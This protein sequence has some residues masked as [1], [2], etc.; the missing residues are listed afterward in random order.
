MVASH[1][2]PIGRVRVPNPETKQYQDIIEETYIEVDLYTDT[3]NKHQT[4]PSLKPKI[5][6]DL[7]FYSI[8][9]LL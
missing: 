4:N 8:S 7:T 5:M 2:R 1:H 6:K 9:F 3:N